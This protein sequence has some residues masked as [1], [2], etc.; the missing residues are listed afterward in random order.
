MKTRIS[1]K[2]RARNSAGMPARP[3]GRPPAPRRPQLGAAPLGHG[4]GIEEEQLDVEQQEHDRD[5]VIADVEPLPGVADRVHARLVGHLL[6]RGDL[7]RARARRWRSA[8]SSAI[9]IATSMNR[10]IG[11]NSVLM[12]AVCLSIHAARQGS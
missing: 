11:V 1:Q 2:T 5:Q 10:K 3:T 12:A 8:C 7:L 6:D 4:P 9:P